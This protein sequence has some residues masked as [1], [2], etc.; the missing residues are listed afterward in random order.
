MSRRLVLRCL[1]NLAHDVESRIRQVND[2]ILEV[3]L[4]LGGFTSVVAAAKKAEKAAMAR[5]AAASGATSKV[6]STASSVAKA[7]SNPKLTAPTARSGM[8]KSSASS[9]KGGVTKPGAKTSQKLDEPEGVEEEEEGELSESDPGSVSIA[10]LERVD[11]ANMLLPLSESPDDTGAANTLSEAVEDELA[12]TTARL[13][14][15]ISRP[16]ANAINASMLREG[17]VAALLK[18]C[19]NPSPLIEV[20]PVA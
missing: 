16:G 3:G 5:E 6:P 8:T 7:A 17:A 1:H 13:I 15:N 10:F 4:A 2:G 14:W 19:T 20:G 11:C 12:E 18:L 9:V